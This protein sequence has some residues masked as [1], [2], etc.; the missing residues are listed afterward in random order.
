[1]SEPRMLTRLIFRRGQAREARHIRGI[2]HR[3]VGLGRDERR[4]RPEQRQM[5]DERTARALDVVDRLA[6][7]EC[8]VVKFRWVLER[9]G[10]RRAVFIVRAGLAIAVGEANVRRNLETASLEPIGP[11]L[12]G[13]NHQAYGP[14]AG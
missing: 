7:E 8:S 13:A 4:M 14:D 1:M 5:R 12:R 11:R 6:D 10:M 3:V 2:V 9:L